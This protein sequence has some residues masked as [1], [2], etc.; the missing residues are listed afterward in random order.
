MVQE[1]AEEYRA[2]TEAKGLRLEVAPM[3]QEY[4]V[5]SDPTR[6]RQILGNLLSNAVKYTPAGAVRV[7]IVWRD[8]PRGGDLLK[9]YGVEVADTGAGIPAEKRE[10]IFQEFTRLEPGAAQGVGLGLAIS[11]RVARLLGGDITVRSEV[12]K[13]SAFTLWIPERGAGCPEPAP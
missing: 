4:D 11:R 2:S 8:R 9:W 5:R 1:V 13:G 3:I 10:H 12:G 7:S 6:L